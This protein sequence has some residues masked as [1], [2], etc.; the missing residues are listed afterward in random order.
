[1]VKSAWSPSDGR[2]I[3]RGP[4]YH[5]DMGEDFLQARLDAREEPRNES[6]FRIA[7]GRWMRV[8]ENR[9]TDGSRVLLTF[10]GPVQPSAT[11]KVREEIETEVGDT[12]ALILERLG[13]SGKLC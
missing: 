4:V 12:T 10:K 8:R 1:M 9:M 11:M 6:S 5:P 2:G 3:A 13:D 7:D